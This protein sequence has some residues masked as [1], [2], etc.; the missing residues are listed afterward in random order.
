MR[1]FKKSD[2]KQGREIMKDSDLNLSRE[3]LELGETP[4]PLAK[5]TKPATSGTHNLQR[6][7][8]HQEIR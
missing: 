7:A 8:S 1:C 4:T 6:D 2:L 3:E 5:E